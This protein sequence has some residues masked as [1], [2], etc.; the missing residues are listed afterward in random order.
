M[1]FENYTALISGVV[2]YMGRGPTDVTT[3]KIDGSIALL[4]A[5]INR[6][7]R[8]AD[9][10]TQTTS[11]TLTTSAL[12]GS[13]SVVTHPADWKAWKNI[14]VVDTAPTDVEIGTQVNALADLNHE[15]PGRP[16]RAFVQNAGTELYPAPDADYAYRYVYYAKV[17][18]LTSAA[19][20][21]WLLT[22]H[23]D[24]YFFGAMSY[25]SVYL[26]NDPRAGMWR[27]EFDRAIQEVKASDRDDKFSGNPLRPI[28]KG[29]V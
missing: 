4:E 22:K 28:V 23:P 6:T 12:T 1:P 10:E 7:L 18:N 27:S 9:M 3:A 17:P 20:T 8:V 13:L 14:K 16:R 29:V 24:V 26:Y 5:H 21:N 2:D 15:F 11:L 19:P 25:M